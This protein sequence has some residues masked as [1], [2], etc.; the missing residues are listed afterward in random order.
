MSRAKIT[1]T[2]QI[3]K[4]LFPFSL[5]LKERSGGYLK[6]SLQSGGRKALIGMIGS[7]ACFTVWYLIRRQRL[8]GIATIVLITLTGIYGLIAVNMV[9]LEDL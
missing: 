5:H 2:Q 3:Y 4:A 7:L 9:G 6:L 1:A 8:P